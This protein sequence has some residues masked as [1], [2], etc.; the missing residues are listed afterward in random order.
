MALTTDTIDKAKALLSEGVQ[1]FGLP[2]R[3]VER[4]GIQHHDGR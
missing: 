2:V 4:A 1:R 3:A